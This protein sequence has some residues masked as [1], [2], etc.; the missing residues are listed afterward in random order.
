MSSE[1]ALI[2]VF[3]PPLAS[4]LALAENKKGAA[5]G[6]AE[7]E[8]IRDKSACIMMESAEA[9]KMAQARGFVDVNPKNCWADWHRLRAQMTGKGYLPKIVLCVPGGDDLPSQ[10]EPLLK[11][12]STEHEFRPHDKNMVRAFNVASTTWPGFT[13]ADFARIESHTTVLY[14]LSKN[15]TAGEAPAIAQRFLSLGRNLLSAGGIAIKSESSGIAHPKS[16]WDKFA[17][18]AA[19]AG[20][21]KWNALF[22][23]YV[24]LPIASKSEFYSCGMHLLG[25]PDLVV[26]QSAVQGSAGKSDIASAIELFRE[27]GL[28]LLSECPTG[29]F[30]SGHT[31]SIKPDAPR[32]RV[33]WEPCE[34]Y[35]EDTLFFNPFGQWRFTNI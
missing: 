19:E 31:F 24:V 23:A 27:F 10:C 17:S 1:P 35:A 29:K 28:Y 26:S 16:R 25:S 3:V 12:E 20:Y 9:E 32:Y 34:R 22:H 6:A 13:P 30:A 5:L 4:V 2:P 8:S 7:V 21:K 11:A 18:D 15:F 14:I 33:L